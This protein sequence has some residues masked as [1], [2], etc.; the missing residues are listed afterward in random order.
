MTGGSTVGECAVCRQGLLHIMKE[1]ISGRFV[2]ICGDCESQ[3]ASPIDAQSYERALD[4]S[5][6]ATKLSP[7]SEA[8]IKALGWDRFLKV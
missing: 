6:E 5:A 8:E 3:W 1:A 2:V 4:A 7:A